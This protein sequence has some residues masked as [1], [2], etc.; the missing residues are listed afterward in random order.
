MEI[1]DDQP[2]SATFFNEGKWLTEFV[3][4]DNLEVQ[5]KYEEI[6][7]GLVTLEE[8]LIACRD[9]VANFPYRKFLSGTLNING[10]ISQQHDLWADPSTVIRVGVGNCSNKSFLLTSLL[11]NVLSPNQVH[12]VLGNLYNGKPG[13][14][15][16]VQVKLDD[17]YIM[18]STQ[19]NVPPLVPV[20]ATQRYEAIH[21]FNDQS[22]YTIPG[23]TVMKPYTACF[24]P[25][26][27]DYLD[28]AYIEGRK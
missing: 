15:A 16:W 14:H 26:L 12:T 4:P 13:G 23:K 2:I 5:A 25:W 20:S 24:S 9:Y 22:L 10:H 18:E 7:A 1:M 21:L 27:E 6:T 17:D 3:T 28:F 8:K 19:P 11:R